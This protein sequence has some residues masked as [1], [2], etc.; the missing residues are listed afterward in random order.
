M[1]VR[2]ALMFWL[3]VVLLGAVTQAAADPVR[4]RI[5]WT[6]TPGHL[7][8]ILEVLTRRHPELFPQSG[9]S[10]VAEAMRFNGGTPQI[11]ALAIG[12][13]EI[14]SFGATALAL[15]I[16]NAHLDL[17]IV[18]DV[19]Q[20]GHPGHYATPYTVRADGPIKRIEDVK[21]HRV[22]SNAIGSLGDSAMRIM[23]RRHGIVDSDFTTVE[24]AFPNML[25]MLDAGKVDLISLREQNIDLLKDT[26]H[27]RALFTLR[28]AVGSAQS[29]WVMRAD[30]VAAHRPALVDFFE[31]HL[32]A[33]RWLLDPANRAE[34]LAATAVATKD[35]PEA[36]GFVFTKNDVW[37]SPDG[38]PEI[39]AVQKEIDLD[40]QYGFLAQR[41][42]VAPRYV[43]LSLIEEAARRLEAQ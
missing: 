2:V 15:A 9:K 28:D 21:G 31:D 35:K 29:I 3:I 23:F 1:G 10:Y 38:L 14:A 37:R 43:D 26:A 25:P 22:A 11:Q 19:M 40:V 30:F 34:A 8:P 6:T 12:D 41:I 7:A 18:A 17:R 24:T 20:Q 33:V 36:L 32:R 16:T 42:A 39:E 5:G 27:Y 13:L 4:L